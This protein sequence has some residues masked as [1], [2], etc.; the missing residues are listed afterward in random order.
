MR[1][2]NLRRLKRIFYGL[3]VIFILLLLSSFTPPL[4][5]K[6]LILGIISLFLIPFYFVLGITLIYLTLK[7]E[8]E[9]KLRVFL[10]L[11]GTSPIVFLIG[12]ILHNLLG[13]LGMKILHIVF[14]FIAILV[15][16]ILFLTGAIGSIVLFRKKGGRHPA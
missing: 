1:D 3:V 12:V 13:A 8:V 2:K 4:A 5:S 7:S 16:P 11:T 6:N 14:F 10:L 9:G 15:S